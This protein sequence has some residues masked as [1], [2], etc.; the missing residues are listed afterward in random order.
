MQHP[1]IPDLL[2]AH[3]A[4]DAPVAMKD[5]EITAFEHGYV[6][7]NHR[8]TPV[9]LPLPGRWHGIQGCGSHVLPAHSAVFF[10]EERS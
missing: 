6:V 5:V 9:S 2:R 3:A 10:E 1:P 8:S 4:P 7:V